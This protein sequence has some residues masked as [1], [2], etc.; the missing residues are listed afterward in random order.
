MI[1]NNLI[2][3]ARITLKDGSMLN[4]DNPHVVK[5]IL[6][7]QLHTHENRFVLKKQSK[8]DRRAKAQRPMQPADFFQEMKKLKV[9]VI[10]H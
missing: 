1:R 8:P 7:Q 9:K 4:E 6:H 2:L 10:N 5:S 3:N